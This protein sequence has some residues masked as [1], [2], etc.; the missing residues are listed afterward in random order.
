MKNKPEK[1][2]VWKNYLMIHMK[3][4]SKKILEHQNS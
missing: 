2:L 1:K 3:N 4:T